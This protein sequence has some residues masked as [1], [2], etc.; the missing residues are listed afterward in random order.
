MKKYL[1]YFALIALT[2]LAVSCGPD[3]DPPVVE[4]DITMTSASAVYYGDLKETDTGFFE[5]TLSNGNAT[6][7][8]ILYLEL[9]GDLKGNAAP[10][11]KNGEYKPGTGNVLTFIAGD[12]TKG[13]LY[14]VTAEGQKTATEVTGGTFNISLSGSTYSITT[15]LTDKDGKEI[16]CK[17][18]GAIKITDETEPVTEDPVVMTSASAIYYGDSKETGTGYFQLDLKNDDESKILFLELFGDLATDT[19]VLKS[20]EYQVGTGNA[21]TFI[22]GDGEEGST[23]TVIESGQTT[24]KQIA[25]GTFNISLSGSTYSITTLLTDVDGNEVECIYEGAITIMDESDPHVMEPVIFTDASGDYYGNY[26]DNDCGNFDIYLESEKYSLFMETFSDKAENP[27]NAIMTAHTYTVVDNYANYTVI[28]GSYNA[29]RGTYVSAQITTDDGTKYAIVGGEFDLALSGSTY[30]LTL[31]FILDDGREFTGSYEG[32]IEF[33]N[34][35]GEGTL[36]TLTGDVN[37]P[38]F[39]SV[40]VYSYGDYYEIGMNNYEV[41]LLGDGMYWDENGSEAGTGY[42]IALE[43]DTPLGPTTELPQGEYHFTDSGNGLVLYPG[44]LAFGMFAIGAWITEYADNEIVNQAPLVGGSMT[45]SKSGTNYTI[46]LA[47]EDDN[48]PAYNITGTYTGSTGFEDM[49]GDEAPIMAPYNA[50]TSIKSKMP[51]QVRTPK[52][53]ETRYSAR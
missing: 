49:T 1:S 15:L 33:S 42:Y 45:V 39:A 52:T 27:D 22:A 6:D 46:T 30:T 5:L 37:I 32:A 38:A 47:F 26:Y 34:Q 43:M 21:L 11:L 23:Y 28:P 10:V 51:V 41:Y 3:E 17:Y 44:E 12:G 19:P 16:K 50:K 20:G 8:H 7:G 9:F 2:T 31:D 35:S 53:G 36:S 25:G 29:D 13:S 48:N 4:T 24:V 40:D 14:T 18:S